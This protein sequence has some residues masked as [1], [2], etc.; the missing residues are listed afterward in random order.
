MSFE[1]SRRVFE[2]SRTR[3][4]ERAILLV[5]AFRANDEGKCWPS[6]PRIAREAGV[7]IRTVTRCLPRTGCDDW[8]QR[9]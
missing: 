8:R 9:K 7:S 3:G 5:L 1:Y 4:P 2:Q 6:L